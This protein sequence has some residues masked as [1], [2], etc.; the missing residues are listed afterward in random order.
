[1]SNPYIGEIRLFAGN[2]APVGWAFCDGQLLAISENDALFNL[3][4]TTYGGDGQST[5]ALPDLRGRV[6]VHMGSDPN[7]GSTYVIGQQGG[8]ETVTLSLQQI[9]THSHVQQASTDAA[10]N[11]YGPSAVTG[12]SATTVFYGAPTTTAAMAANAITSAGSSL[13]HDNMAPYLA[14]S[15]IIS[16]FGIFPTQN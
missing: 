5:F 8:A 9:P 7:G 4:G 1:M 12:A 13:P 16:L 15:F 14:L 2:F 3:I 10:S 11:A 6:P